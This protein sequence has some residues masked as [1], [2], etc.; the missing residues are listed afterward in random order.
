MGAAAGGAITGAVAGATLGLGVS[1]VGLLAGS[2]AGVVGGMVERRIA[3]DPDERWDDVREIAKDAYGSLAG[4]A[5]AGRVG[6]VAGGNI[7]K[8][9]TN[10]EPFDQA[11]RNAH[12]FTLANLGR[13]GYQ[14]KYLRMQRMRVGE[15]TPTSVAVGVDSTIGKLT[16][17]PVKPA[18]G[19]LFNVLYSPKTYEC[20]NC[21][22]RYCLTEDCK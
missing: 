8:L 13:Q 11:F 21:T 12:R 18:I 4:G 14:A 7:M 22:M 15:Y 6:H 1:A 2:G 20:P 3:G 17:Y 16:D 10:S 19:W 9:I 5:I